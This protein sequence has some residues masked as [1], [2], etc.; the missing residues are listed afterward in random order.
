[1]HP[2]VTK[3]A[4]KEER[5]WRGDGGKEGEAAGPGCGGPGGQR[6]GQGLQEAR[7]AREEA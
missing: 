2:A 7:P 3:H 5:Q 1:M 6:G 4:P